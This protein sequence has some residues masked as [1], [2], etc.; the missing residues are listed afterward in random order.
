MSVE[1]SKDRQ[2]GLGV[3]QRGRILRTNTG[4]LL[5]AA[6]PLAALLSTAALAS[7]SDV[8]HV[9]DLGGG[10]YTLTTTLANTTDPAHGQL[11]IV[12]KAEDLCGDRFP[13][14]GHYRFDSEAP[15]KATAE[16]GSTTLTYTQEIECRDTPEAASQ[17]AAS[18]AP[19]APST[20]PTDDDATLIRNRTLAYLQAKDAANADVAYAML[21]DEMASYA[22]PEAWAK[23]HGDFHAKAGV[24]A[25]PA[26]IRITWYDDPK[27]APT[28]GR[29]VAADYR[30]DY[31]SD[32]FTC[33]YVVWLRQAGGDYLIVREEEAEITPD[34]TAGLSPEQRLA[35]RA[36]MQCRD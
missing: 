5:D 7:G 27:D 18:P 35:M 13:N 8:V 30:V 36:Q 29:Y 16:T 19:P 20:P 11:A 33:G 26:V 9:E 22:A 6:L 3:R 21:S 34:V 28:P 10:R 4:L 17:T 14:Y 24:V 12:P 23:A 2:G 15:M 32:A 1:T 25:Q 31:P